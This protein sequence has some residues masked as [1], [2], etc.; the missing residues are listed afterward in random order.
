[1]ASNGEIMR[2]DISEGDMVKF[3]DF[4]GNE[5]MIEGEEYS[6]VRMPDILAKF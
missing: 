4:A 1:M 3:R 6:V 5:V 2:V